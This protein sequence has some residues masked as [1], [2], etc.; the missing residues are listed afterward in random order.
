MSINI[1]HVPKDMY[2]ANDF[3]EACDI[4]CEANVWKG[5]SMEHVVH[6]GYVIRKSM[7]R[8]DLYLVVR[9]DCINDEIR[10]NY[11]K[12]GKE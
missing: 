5:T 6:P 1:G 8:Q 3:T 9:V 4:Q 12:C 11:T 7:L 10:S 2:V